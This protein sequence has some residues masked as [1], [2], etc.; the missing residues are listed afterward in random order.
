MRAITAK[1]IAAF[2]LHLNG[3]QWDG[4]WTEVRV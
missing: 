2:D 1:A 3:E 4:K